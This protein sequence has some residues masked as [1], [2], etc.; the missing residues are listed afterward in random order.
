[1]FLKFRSKSEYFSEIRKTD[2]LTERRQKN[3]TTTDIVKN[4]RTRDKKI[5]SLLSW[6]QHTIRL[7]AV[8]ISGK[9]SFSG[10]GIFHGTLPCHKLEE[11]RTLS[12]EDY[13]SGG[14]VPQRLLYVKGIYKADFIAT[15]MSLNFELT[16]VLFDILEYEWLERGKGQSISNGFNIELSHKNI[17]K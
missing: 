11:I 10:E 7:L 1:M 14:L 12:Q 15:W 16:P 8:D 5:R 13:G 6:Q 3:R 2:I 4:G 17:L 9:G